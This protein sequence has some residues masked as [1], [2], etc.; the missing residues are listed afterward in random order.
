MNAFGKFVLFSEAVEKEYI[1]SLGKSPV[2]TRELRNMLMNNTD[3]E[4]ANNLIDGFAYGFKINY[5]GPLLKIKQIYQTH[6][7]SYL[8]K[9]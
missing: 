7:L 5:T 1:W 3:Y 4:S 6:S 9:T 8:S 2:N